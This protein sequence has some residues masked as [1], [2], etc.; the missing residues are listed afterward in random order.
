[1]VNV[2][3]HASIF[4]YG[5]TEK[6]TLAVLVPVVQYE[7]SVDTGFYRTKRLEE[8]RLFRTDKPDLELLQDHLFREGCSMLN[9]RCGFP[10]HLP[11]GRL[12]IKA[13]QGLLN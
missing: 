10:H 8:F 13:A 7:T 3:G 11:S 4:A 1:M 2:K 9:A 12:E 6:L 5:L